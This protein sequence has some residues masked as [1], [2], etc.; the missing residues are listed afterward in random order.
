M[1]TMIERRTV[2][3]ERLGETMEQAE[4]EFLPKLRVAP[5]FTGFYLVVDEPHGVNTA[6]IVWESKAQ[7]DAFDAVNS[8]WMR[9]LES[10]GH[11]LESDNRGE[12][13]LRIESTP[14]PD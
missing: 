11:T 10:L 7:A 6:I 3:R 4:R 5:G 14:A 13:V 12:T 8:R 2:N 9:T 1:Y